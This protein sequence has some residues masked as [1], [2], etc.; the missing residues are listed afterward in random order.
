MSTTSRDLYNAEA[1]SN[2]F[3]ALINSFSRLLLFLYDED[4]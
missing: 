2:K 1:G 3:Q 4:S